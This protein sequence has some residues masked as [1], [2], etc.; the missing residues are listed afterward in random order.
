[1]ANEVQ[2]S[3]NPANS[4]TLAGTF[5][6]I[7]GKFLQNE[8]DDMLPAEVIAYDRPTNRVSVR[9][10]VRL[11]RTDNTLLDRADIASIPVLTLGGGNVVLSFN[12]VPGDIGWIKANDRDISLVLQSEGSAGP[13][14]IRKHSFSDAI[15]IPHQFRSK[16]TL[17]SEDDAFAVLQTLDGTQ[18]ISIHD[19][20]LKLTSDAVVE[21]DAPLLSTTGAIE[22][23]GEI[24]A[25]A[26]GGGSVTLTGH[27]HAQ[28]NDSAGD[29]EVN[30]NPPTAGT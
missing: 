22:A 16:W 7:L 21:I 17:E 10:L 25:N 9:P 4:G 11:L 13:N 8:V 29:S 6:E 15:F 28:G 2:N 20:R 14:T 19:D 30:T 12:I 24:T 3:R 23:A 1:M 27:D 18:R 26:G 5:Q